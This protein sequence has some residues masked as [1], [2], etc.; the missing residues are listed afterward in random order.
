MESPSARCGQPRRR[1]PSG[2]LTPAGSGPGRGGV[3]A[4]GS[5]GR[6]APNRTGSQF[7]RGA[8]SLAGCLGA[9]GVP[10]GL[11][12]R[13]SSL[14]ASRLARSRAVGRAL[15][16]SS[17][18]HPSACPG[19][20]ARVT[21]AQPASPPGLVMSHP[22]GAQCLRQGRPAR[23][24]AAAAREPAGDEVQP[25]RRTKQRVE[26]VAR[27]PSQLSGSPS[28]FFPS[29]HRT[30]PQDRTAPVGATP[31]ASDS[32]GLGSPALL[33]ALLSWS[34]PWRRMPCPDLLLLL[35]LLLHQASACEDL[36]CFAD[37][38]ETLTCTWGSR[39]EPAS[40]TGSWDCGEGGTCPF[41]PAAAAAAAAADGNTTTA[42]P[43]WTCRADQR[44]CF[45]NAR[46]QVE[47]A[48]PGPGPGEAPLRRCRKAFVFQ[49]HIQ[50]SPP[51]NLTAVASPAG[52]TV[53]WGTRYR[54]G[55]YLRGEL[56]Y[57]LSYRR[58]SQP[59]PEPGQKRLSRDTQTLQLLPHELEAGA[60]YELRVRARPGEASSYRGTWS[61]W[62]RGATLV[63]L[64]RPS[65]DA[66]GALWLLL[67]LLSLVPALLAF[68][69]W[70][71]GLWKKLNPL[72]PSPAP[73]FQPLFLVHKGDFKKWVGAYSARGVLDISEWGP[74]VP[75]ICQK[76]GVKY[77]PP[78]SPAKGGWRG[79]REALQAGALPSSLLISADNRREGKQEEATMS[80]PPYGHLSIDTVT[81]AGELP[82]CCPPCGRAG[83]C[84]VTER[85]Q[86]KENPET[87]A[88]GDAYCGFCPEGASNGQVSGPFLPWTRGSPSP[89]CSESRMES[90]LWEEAAPALVQTGGFLGR[91][92]ADKREPPGLCPVP[93]E[94][95]WMATPLSL[96]SPQA[97][98]AP[99]YREL[100]SPELDT[101]GNAR[102]GLD[103]DT[104]DSGFADCEC[105]SPLDAECQE[106]QAGCGSVGAEEE[107]EAFLASYVKQWVSCHKGKA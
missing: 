63:T 76:I 105:G 31:Q 4:R 19:I 71:R 34:C 58:R 89:C 84:C 85:W 60:E 10:A 95:L 97:E 6:A 14:L 37:Y 15:P 33:G 69:G 46:F 5:G 103:L 50:P 57:E 17:S 96:S 82:H 47:A 41:G 11:C 8:E 73:F 80:E 36:A 43:H 67:L 72:V 70:H 91:R 1:L 83:L 20:G 26:R 81:V 68:L 25:D 45:G 65:D 64:P 101:E 21:S 93:F 27:G 99:F 62:S 3:A 87:T 39:P 24:Q 54:R 75:E 32:A 90:P 56:Q 7:A 79:D 38:L 55:D 78:P 18:P 94:T 22:A 98:E 44:A 9:T 104:I 86:E 30:L 107:K 59:W 23:A 53:S 52:Y 40:L 13:C 42:A 35:L 29:G 88:E 16:P 2:A 92:A 106:G 28:V 77:L 100:L 48:V 74:V 102:N 49:D 66:G 12:R 51:F 61:D